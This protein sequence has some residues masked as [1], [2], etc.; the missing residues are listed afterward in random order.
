MRHRSVADPLNLAGII[1]PGKKVPALSGNR[2]LFENGVP[3]A[4]QTGGEVQYLKDVDEKSQWEI[5]NLLV[6]KQRP[7]GYLELSRTPQ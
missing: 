6:R 3:V 4:V 2:V 1:T 7:G 5:R